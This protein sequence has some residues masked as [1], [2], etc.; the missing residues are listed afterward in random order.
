MAKKARRIRRLS[1]TQTYEPV[2]AQSAAEQPLTARAA[3]TVDFREEYRYI[4][5]D[6][7]RI[8]ILAAAIV[9]AL[10]IASLFIK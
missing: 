8:G 2:P 4:L 6:L 7:Q 1:A 10:V 5:A 9:A 3:R